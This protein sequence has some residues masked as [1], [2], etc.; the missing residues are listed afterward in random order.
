MLENNAVMMRLLPIAVV[1]VLVPSW[2]EALAEEIPVGTIVSDWSEYSGVFTAINIAL[3]QQQLAGGNAGNSSKFVTFKLWADRIKT[4]DAYKL[5]KIICRQVRNH[6][7]Q[8][9]D[10]L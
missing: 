10:L 4:V 3:A 8:C 1:L 6:L 5:S 7:K 9:I 2:Q